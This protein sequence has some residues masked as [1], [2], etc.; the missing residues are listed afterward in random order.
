MILLT[1]ILYTSFPFLIIDAV[2]PIKHRPL[3]NVN[4]SELCLLDVILA[5][6]APFFIK[7]LV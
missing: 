5:K 6:V 3:E 4:L 2:F 1:I 7:L